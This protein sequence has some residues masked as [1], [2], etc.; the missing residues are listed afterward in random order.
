LGG[1]LA[2]GGV[3]EGEGK[4]GTFIELAYRLEDAF[5]RRG[6]GDEKNV[7]GISKGRGAAKKKKVGSSLGSSSQ[8]GHRE[9]RRRKGGLIPKKPRLEGFSKG[10]KSLPIRKNLWTITDSAEKNY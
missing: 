10:S 7:V 1:K 4:N 3:Q 6:G 9:I 5:V 2:G 8:G